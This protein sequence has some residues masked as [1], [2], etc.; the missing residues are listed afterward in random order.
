MSL[1]E[2][3]PNEV[4]YEILSHLNHNDIVNI[5]KSS[6]KLREFCKS[7]LGQQLLNEKINEVIEGANA[8]QP[9]YT[10][11]T[12]QGKIIISLVDEL[13]QSH[14]NTTNVLYNILPRNKKEKYL[15]IIIHR[16][17][18]QNN[19]N[20]DALDYIL[21]L[22]DNKGRQ[23]GIIL[24][25]IGT[26]INNNNYNLVKYFGELIKQK[27]ISID[28]EDLLTEIDEDRQND[29]I[30]YGYGIAMRNNNYKLV[31]YFG[32]LIKEKN[33]SI[34]IDD[35]EDL[36]NEIDAEPDEIPNNIYIYIL[37]LI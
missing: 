28:I 3:S 17:L 14:F 16:Y 31:K 20:F 11:N 21:S 33:I 36:L 29:L 32:E 4:K 15:A 34:N 27:N 10:K 22:T 23:T 24:Y 19:I 35:V 1:I 9:I 37:T 8:T 26:A 13:V 25:G 2:L 7:Q 5:C 12:R 30:L 18:N 6:W